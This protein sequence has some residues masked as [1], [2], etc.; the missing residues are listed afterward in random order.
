MADIERLATELAALSPNDRELTLQRMQVI[1]VRARDAGNRLAGGKTRMWADLIGE[2][3]YDTYGVAV[4]VVRNIKMKTQDPDNPRD[5]QSWRNAEH[6][7][8]QGVTTIEI[9][10]DAM[11]RS[12]P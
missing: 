3:L 11:R 7:M 4:A 12:A 9:I 1:G 2:K 10:A 8:Q 5:P 6:R